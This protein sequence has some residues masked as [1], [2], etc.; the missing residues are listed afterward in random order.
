MFNTKIDP[1][2]ATAGVVPAL[3]ANPDSDA[4]GAIMTED[5]F[6]SR[7]GTVIS[8]VDPTK[9]MIRHFQRVGHYKDGKLLQAGAAIANQVRY[10]EFPG[11]RLLEKTRMT[12]NGNE[13][14]RYNY[15]SYVFYRQFELDITKR[16]AYFKGVGQQLENDAAEHSNGGYSVVYKHVNGPQTPKDVQPEL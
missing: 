3:P 16:P 11:E 1:V 6:V 14:D 9:K 8:N 2:T 15:M 4:F 10:V 12:V 5:S 13:L 7:D